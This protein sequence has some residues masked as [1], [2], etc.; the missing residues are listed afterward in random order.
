M[1]KN[2]AGILLLGLALVLCAC[3]AAPSKTVIK[4]SVGDLAIAS[5]QTVNTVHGVAAP[6]NYTI[7]LIKLERV[8]GKDF[9]V[10]DLQK[11]Q[12]D[13]KVVILGEDGAP[14]ACTM[15]GLLEDGSMALG[16]PLPASF[17]K[18]TLSWD[19][20]PAIEISLSSK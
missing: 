14:Y 19:G 1:K 2:I 5:T 16:C 12:M 3:T 9:L 11:A 18:S 20:N 8:D 13:G 10:E 7:L 17:K 4:T 6:E 15:G